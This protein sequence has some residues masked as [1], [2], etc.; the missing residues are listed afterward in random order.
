M[1][2]VGSVLKICIISLSCLAFSTTYKDSVITLK[3]FVS[4]IGRCPVVPKNHTLT[5]L[6]LYMLQINMALIMSIFLIIHSDI[7]YSGIAGY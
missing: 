7:K 3:C 5:F 4:N 2:Y 6:R 1:V